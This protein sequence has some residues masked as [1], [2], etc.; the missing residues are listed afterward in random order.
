MLWL[1][2]F[3]THSHEN[4]QIYKDGKTNFH[5]PGDIWDLM[6]GKED[7]RLLDKLTHFL[8]DIGIT[9]VFRDI[10]E[11]CFLPGIL[12]TEGE[13]HIDK[14]KLLY[15]GDVLHEAGHIAI[16]PPSERHTLN[17]LSIGERPMHEAEEMMAI[18]WS[19]AVALH[20]EID[21]HIVFH[22]HGY[23]GGGGF[24]ADNFL[25]GRYFGVPMLQ[26]TEMAWEKFDPENPERPVY[27]KMRKWMRG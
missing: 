9:I 11:D 15:V 5:F 27:P 23:K 1:N 13:M 14:E 18:A 10:E 22:D 6:N 26:W 17:D 21:P 24:I 2:N 8:N 19:F 4:S 3:I 25:E 16:V 12:I 20:L 7:H